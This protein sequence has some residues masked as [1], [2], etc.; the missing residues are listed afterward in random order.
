MCKK[1][2]KHNIPRIMISAMSSDSG[3]TMFTC[4]FLK[5]LKDRGYNVAAF[6]CG[7]DYI[8]PMFHRKALGIETGN[9]DA[10]FTSENTL[11]YLFSL[12][13][14]GKDIAVMEGV[15]G[16]YDGISGKDIDRYTGSSH[17]IANLT[18]TDALLIVNG[19]SSGITLSAAIKGI[20]DYESNCK[21]KGVILNR[22]SKNYYPKLKAEIE[23]KA[24]IKVYG[25]IPEL[26]KA[27]IPNRHLGLV[28]PSE[29]KDFQQWIDTVAAAIEENVD[30]EEIIKLASKSTTLEYEDIAIEPYA[31]NKRV[32]I[33]KDEA[34]SFYYAEN[35]KYL[36]MLGCEIEY[37]SPL[38][39]KEL[40]KNIDAI[41]LYGGYPELFCEQLSASPIR[42]KIKEAVENGIICIAECGG[43]MY[44]NNCFEEIKDGVRIEHKWIGLLDGKTYMTDKLCRFGYVDI[45]LEKDG[46]AGKTGTHIRA[47]EF[48]YC[49]CTDNGEDCLVTK[50]STGQ[51]YRAMVHKDKILA[52]F[53]HMYYWGQV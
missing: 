47:H 44:L 1:I 41:I 52:G 19:K 21:V 11:K 40:P 2:I 16:Y 17:H 38:H 39:D 45:T 28:N 51:Q 30:V 20:I 33:A 6:K 13:S 18:D 24:G 5:V 35:I 10:Y 14:S 43:F 53:L 32:A 22:V 46:I 34:F 15:M 50:A 27:Y 48:H 37:F 31:K 12:E 3:K 9:L 7:P 49:D 23:E 25:F 42:L 26:K 36:Q 8:D 29:L 4:G